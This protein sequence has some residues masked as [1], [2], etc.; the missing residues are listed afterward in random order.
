MGN[1]PVCSH[2]QW[3]CMRS[4][5][6]AWGRE[7]GR[8]WVEG[9]ACAEAQ[10]REPLG[11]QSGSVSVDQE[12]A[13]LVAEQRKGCA[14]LTSGAQHRPGTSRG[15]CPGS[16]AGAS[17]SVHHHPRSTSLRFLIIPLACCC[18]SPGISKKISIL[19]SSQTKQNWEG[20]SAAPP[21]PPPQ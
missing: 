4:I 5:A 8:V 16:P 14:L 15:T 6:G 18:C 13:G 11:V 3:R 2:V 19:L 1:G 10:R 7:R 9:T 20:E 12:S 17:C 21:A